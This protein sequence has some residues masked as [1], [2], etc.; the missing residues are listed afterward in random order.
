M[1]PQMDDV[2]IWMK[3]I[4]FELRY[5]DEY[6]RSVLHRVQQKNV[7]SFLNLTSDKPGFYRLTILVDNKSR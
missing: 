6:Q 3:V 5:I 7:A 2:F 1:D 4:G